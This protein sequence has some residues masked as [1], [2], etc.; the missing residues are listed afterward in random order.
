LAGAENRQPAAADKERVLAV[1]AMRWLSIGAAMWLFVAFAN[2]QATNTAQLAAA[3]AIAG[4]VTDTLTGEPLSGVN[5]RLLAIRSR[6]A[7]PPSTA[8]SQSD[9]TFHFDT[10]SAGTYILRGERAGYLSTSN[11]ARG[12]RIQLGADQ[13]L[14]DVSLKMMPESKISG[15]VYDDTGHAVAAVHVRALEKEMFVGRVQVIERSSGDT[16][17]NGV[18]SVGKLRPGKYMLVADPP[19][20]A[21]PQQDSNGDLVTTLFPRT[22]NLEEAEEVEIAPGYSPSDLKIYLQRAA[23]HH[24]RGR[25]A[26]FLLYT[27]HTNVFLAPRLADTS[28]ALTRKVDV[29]KNGTFDVA[30][31]VPGSYVL[32]AVSDR[33][34]NLLARTEVE[35]GAGD[36]S[37]VVLTSLPAIAISGLARMDEGELPPDAR[38][39]VIARPLI[40]DYSHPLVAATVTDGTFQVESLH[41]EPYVFRAVPSMRGVYVEAILLNGQDILGKLVDI[42]DVPVGR[43]EIVL[44]NGAATIAGTVEVPSDDNPSGI[45][46]VLVPK[47][48]DPVGS[49]IQFA[50]TDQNGA[51]R[52]G[53][54]RPDEYTLYALHSAD[55]DIWLN[56]AFLQQIAAQGTSV[57]VTENQQQQVQMKLIPYEAIAQAALLS[58]VPDN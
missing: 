13:F 24:I 30:G 27:A 23:A 9:G 11:F 44:R 48:V 20:A 26:D 32:R 17:A 40:E 54:I 58:G 21:H 2:A 29:A 5:V 39:R 6:A 34:S 18:F 3:S 42:A 15:R 37:D 10:L 47:Q 31:V 49:N 38:V 35:V 25:I 56:T 7:H 1:G 33:R 45:S 14:N 4:R 22:S 16:D 43:M 53:N 55:P 28:L 57:T 36:V 51:F 19:Q 46:I 8:E 52:V 50:S 41:P 12:P